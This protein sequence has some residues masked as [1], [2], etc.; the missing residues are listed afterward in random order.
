MLNDSFVRFSTC[1]TLF[2]TWSLLNFKERILVQLF[3]SNFAFKERLTDF[4]DHIIKT[5]CTK[6]HRAWKNMGKLKEMKRIL[7]GYNALE[8]IVLRSASIIFPYSFFLSNCFACYVRFI[9][10]V[11]NP[12]EPKQELYERRQNLFL[13]LSRAL[14]TNIGKHI[15]VHFL[16]M[17]LCLYI[18]A[19]I[20]NN[21]S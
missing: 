11:A 15:Y 13:S 7:R 4:L 19:Q 21:I 2:S 20:S 16:L 3:T 14:R 1:F 12:S 17:H 6:Q 9:L 8:S 5:A 10:S 18:C